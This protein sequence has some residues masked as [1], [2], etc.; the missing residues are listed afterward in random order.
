MLL[1]L[2][3]ALHQAAV[4]LS[5][6]GTST[7]AEQHGDDELH[8]TGTLAGTHPSSQ[9]RERR[10][11]RPKQGL[12]VWHNTPG[13]YIECTCKLTTTK[14]TRQNNNISRYKYFKRATT[15]YKHL[16]IKHVINITLIWHEYKQHGNHE[17]I[18]G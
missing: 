11:T 14:A 7:A 9:H 18:A 1:R 8:S 15:S 3:S 17:C 16:I 13:Q 4:E 5:S 2:A 12:Q 10:P 6:S